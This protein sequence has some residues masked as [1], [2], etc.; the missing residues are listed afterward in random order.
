MG[1]PPSA[2][3]DALTTI[4]SGADRYANVENWMIHE[5]KTIKP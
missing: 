5:Q 3:A 4:N 2:S 1:L